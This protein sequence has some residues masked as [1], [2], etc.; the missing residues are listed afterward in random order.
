[1]KKG[2]TGLEFLII[3]TIIGFAVASYEVATEGGFSEFIG[4]KKEKVSVEST[5][6]EM[7]LKDLKTSK[8]GFTVSDSNCTY[9]Y[10]LKDDMLKTCSKS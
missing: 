8:E 4:V 9:T 1:M 6:K 2:F 5:L 3:P 10:T 7:N